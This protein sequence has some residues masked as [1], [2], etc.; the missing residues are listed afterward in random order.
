MKISAAVLASAAVIVNGQEQ[1]TVLP[2]MVSLGMQDPVC[3]AS[4]TALIA[5]TAISQG[6][7]GMIQNCEIGDYFSDGPCAGDGKSPTDTVLL[8]GRI[9][10]CCL[11]LDGTLCSTQILIGGAGDATGSMNSM[12]PS[13]FDT[14]GDQVFDMC[15]DVQCDDEDG[16][17]HGAESS[18]T[19]DHDDHDDHD[20][21]DHDDHDDEDGDDH[22][23]ESS[24]T[25]DHDDHDDHDGHDHDDHDD[26][27]SAA[28]RTV[29]GVTALVSAVAM[30]LL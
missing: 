30:L 6:M 15:A 13:T 26:D 12:V 11:V 1:C 5:Q 24:S 8:E 7:G 28:P 14:D 23:A 17:D 20:G 2:G 29:L 16:D 9:N 18:S 10:L 4:A 22:G 21:H 27:Y 25:G 19:G 3:C